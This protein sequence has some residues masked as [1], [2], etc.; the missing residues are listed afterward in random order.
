MMILLKFIIT[1]ILIIVVGISES[2]A[3]EKR[4]MLYWNLKN[5]EDTSSFFYPGSVTI[6]YDDGKNETLK[7]SYLIKT[8]TENPWVQWNVDLEDWEIEK[9]TGVIWVDCHFLRVKYPEDVYEYI[10][11]REFLISNGEELFDLD[12]ERINILDELINPSNIE[13]QMFWLRFEN[14]RLFRLWKYALINSSGMNIFAYRDV[15]ERMREE[16]MEATQDKKRNKKYLEKLQ[17]EMSTLITFWEEYFEQFKEEMREIEIEKIR[18]Q[19][20]R[21][22]SVITDADEDR[23]QETSADCSASLR[24][25]A[26]DDITAHSDSS[27]GMPSS[28]DISAAIA[29]EDI[30]HK[31][32]KEQE[33]T[34]RTV[35]KS[36]EDDTSLS[37]F[38]TFSTQSSSLSEQSSSLSDLS[39]NTMSSDTRESYSSS[40]PIITNSAYSSTA[41]S[42][43]QERIDSSGLHTPKSPSSNSNVSSLLST[44]SLGTKKSINHTPSSLSKIDS[45][46]SIMIQYHNKPEIK[47]H[48]GTDV[49]S[50][51]VPE[52]F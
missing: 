30:E 40:S 31:N 26:V 27:S 24:E 42:E 35:E 12:P 22:L 29:I 37:D 28:S 2:D 36:S 46:R 7:L 1:Y 16:E 32:D 5:K 34:A 20:N 50:I 10:I 41:D 43:H 45:G 47:D 13:D 17:I 39:S 21:S 33:F 9:E 15:Y 44:D 52:R 4:D 48:I 19:Y 51:S 23:K 6:E 49:T 8:L 11:Q 25:L 38:P 18:A 14:Y 3:A